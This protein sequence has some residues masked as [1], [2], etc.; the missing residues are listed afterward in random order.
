MANC[1]KCQATC[2]VIRQGAIICNQCGA[3]QTSDRPT[4][5]VQEV[6]THNTGLRHSERVQRQTLSEKEQLALQ[7]AYDVHTKDSIDEKTPKV[8]I[9]MPTFK[10]EHTIFKT[11]GSICAQTY[12]NWEL[13]VVDNESGHSYRFNDSRI[14][15]VQHT[16][17]RGAAYARNKGVDYISGSLVCFFDDDDIMESDYLELM[18]KAFENPAV[19]VVSCKIKLVEGR[20]AE[21]REFC[22][23]T[24]ML[25]REIASATWAADYGHDTEYFNRV[26]NSISVDA[27]VEINNV[28]VRSYTSS[29]GGLRADDAAL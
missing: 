17:T 11:I 26:V 10:R 12:P 15:Y 13:I 14:K 6:K 16:E 4:R 28:L 2:I 1:F 27:Y 5:R 19:K 7:E 23:P 9:V 18:V 25:R 29:E 24:V 20:I 21:N 22:T 8:S 3:V